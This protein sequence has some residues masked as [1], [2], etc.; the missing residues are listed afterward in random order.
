MASQF[1]GGDADALAAA[2]Y[3]AES[4]AVATHLDIVGRLAGVDGATTLSSYLIVESQH[5]T[6]LADMAGNGDDLDALLTNTA[7]SIAPAGGT[8][9]P[10]ETGE[11]AGA[12]V[13][14]PDS[15]APTVPDSTEG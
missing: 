9:A 12:E 2:A 5:C 10:V 7:T 8:S 6:V 4:Q 14:S 11:V 1:D 13:S 3:D 15:A